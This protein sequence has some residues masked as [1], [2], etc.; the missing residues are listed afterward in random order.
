MKFPTG[1][2]Y[3]L[4]IDHFHK[5]LREFTPSAK[6]PESTLMTDGRIF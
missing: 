1:L 3:I 6:P 2:L 4:S 5:R